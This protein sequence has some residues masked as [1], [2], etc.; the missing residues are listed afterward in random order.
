MLHESCCHSEDVAK[1]ASTKPFWT[2]LEN[3]V[4]VGSYVCAFTLA[5][6][7]RTSAIIA[8]VIAV[9]LGTLYGGVSSILACRCNSRFAADNYAIHEAFGRWHLQRCQQVCAVYGKLLCVKRDQ[10]Q[11]RKAR[12]PGSTL[13]AATIS[14][15]SLGRSALLAACHSS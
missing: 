13:F 12:V 7:M 5:G 1:I 8:L 3:S 6:L 11:G 4:L 9:A 15:T 2:E 14:F 10:H